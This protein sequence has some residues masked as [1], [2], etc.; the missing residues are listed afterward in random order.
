MDI[1][2]ALLVKRT[3]ILL[4]SILMVKVDAIHPINSM[5]FSHYYK[6]AKD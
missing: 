3:L 1:L 4:E 6:A 2:Y 5:A